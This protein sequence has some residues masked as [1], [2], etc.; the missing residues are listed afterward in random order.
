MALLVL[1]FLKDRELSLQLQQ[2]LL[3]VIYDDCPEAY[4]ILL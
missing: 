3:M 4:A 1:L 2:G